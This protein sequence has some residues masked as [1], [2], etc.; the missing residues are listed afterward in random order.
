M[1]HR[2]GHVVGN[3]ESGFSHIVWYFSAV[4]GIR[5][6]WARC[7]RWGNLLRGCRHQSRVWSPVVHVVT[8]V[9]D[10]W[11]NWGTAE[12]SSQEQAK[13]K[14]SIPRDSRT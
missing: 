12:N 14:L 11:K 6:A 7:T 9:P 10:E 13:A 1:A 4:Q 2:W 5:V 8:Y 3:L